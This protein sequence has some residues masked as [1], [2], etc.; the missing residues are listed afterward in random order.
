M[1]TE[2]TGLTHEY[3]ARAHLGA[4]GIRYVTCSCDR[5]GLMVQGETATETW[6]AGRRAWSRHAVLQED[7]REIRTRMLA[8]TRRLLSDVERSTCLNTLEYRHLEYGR[9]D[10]PGRDAARDALVTHMARQQLEI[11]RLREALDAYGSDE[12]C[13]RCGLPIWIPD[14]GVFHASCSCGATY[15]RTREMDA[16]GRDHAA[17]RADLLNDDR[18]VGMA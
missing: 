12:P 6:A 9:A 3:I 2:T 1:T 4:E 10:I 8:D 14:D 7:P 15:R 18:R 11:A 13:G 5:W 16:P 17:N